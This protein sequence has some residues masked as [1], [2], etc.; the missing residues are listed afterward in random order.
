[1]HI[2]RR[3]FLSLTAAAGVGLAC[4]GRMYAAEFKT[5]IQK[6][7]IV[8]S[9]KTD[10]E[11]KKIKDQGY[12]G[13]ET[14]SC[15]VKPEEAAKMREAAEKRLR[16][17]LMTTLVAALGL[18]PAALSNGIGAQTQKPLALVVIGG[19]LMLAVLTRL[20]QPPMLLV[21]HRWREAYRARRPTRAAL[22]QAEET[23]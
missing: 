1:M 12:D 18:L 8:G 21:A 20:L 10:D 9:P 2:D 11:W 22:A 13:V 7:C 6:A 3:N 15:G 19:A 17:V 23:S 16:P 4:G 14:T 5:K